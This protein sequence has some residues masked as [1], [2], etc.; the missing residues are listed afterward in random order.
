MRMG[1]K[2]YEQALFL[3]ERALEMVCR[4]G[5]IETIGAGGFGRRVHCDGFN[6]W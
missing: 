2:K 3:M 6:V 1:P 5:I 4:H